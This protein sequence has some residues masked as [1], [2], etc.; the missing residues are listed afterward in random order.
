MHKLSIAWAAHS[1]RHTRRH[2]CRQYVVINLSVSKFAEQCCQC[3]QRIVHALVQVERGRLSSTLPRS[4]LA[5]V[6]LQDTVGTS[7][8]FILAC[9]AWDPSNSIVTAVAD[10]AGCS[11]LWSNIEMPAACQCLFRR[12]RTKSS[13][14]WLSMSLSARMT[15]QLMTAQM[16]VQMTVQMTAQPEKIPRAMI[17][18]AKRRPR[19]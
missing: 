6:P 2:T 4:R 18:S 5:L 11:H 19:S 1:M 13:T 7:L 12:C 9:L 14:T 16:T 3:V 15:T 10:S 17:H 8:L